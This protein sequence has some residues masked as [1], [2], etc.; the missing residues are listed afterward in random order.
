MFGDIIKNWRDI[1]YPLLF[2]VSISYL[3][4]ILARYLSDRFGSSTEEENLAFVVEQ[5]NCSTYKVFCVS[6]A[7]WNIG[8]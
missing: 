7:R 8:R 2:M 3:A 1:V 4:A 6:G 5:L